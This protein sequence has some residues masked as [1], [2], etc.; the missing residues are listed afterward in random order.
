MIDI[1]LKIVIQYRSDGQISRSAV[2]NAV[3]N[4][5]LAAHPAEVFSIP[6]S[7]TYAG[8]TVSLEPKTKRRANP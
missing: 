6:D 5:I 1:E 3:C 4:A 2:H 7:A 8:Y